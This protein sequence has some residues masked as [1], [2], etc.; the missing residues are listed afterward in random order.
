[1]SPKTYLIVLLMI[2]SYSV[3]SQDT[4]FKKDSSRIICTITSVDR[5]FIY[6]N[7]YP[8]PDSAVSKIKIDEVRLFRYGIGFQDKEDFNKKLGNLFFSGTSKLSVFIETGYT[9][10]LTDN[11]INLFYS[12]KDYKKGLK[13]GYYL[14]SGFSM[15][16]K[17]SGLGYK[18][19]WDFFYN[20][21]DNHIFIDQFNYKYNKISDKIKLK[22]FG[23]V[24]Y[25]RKILENKKLFLISGFSGM[26]SK[27]FDNAV[28][29]SKSFNREFYIEAMNIG[30]EASFSAEYQLYKWLGL[31]ASASGFFTYFKKYQMNSTIYYL[32]NNV[33]IIKTSVSG[34]VRFYL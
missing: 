2:G 6:Y 26:L 27:Y 11:Y 30:F 3:K 33:N 14:N 4:I 20:E 5:H 9:G 15:F 17:N 12:G 31:G 1:M 16:F 10:L 21:N 32:E 13:N 19:F 22:S 8:L 25:N 24:F 7:N 23:P 18:I 34:G 28:I 29:Y